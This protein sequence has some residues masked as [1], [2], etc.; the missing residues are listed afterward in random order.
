M[1]DVSP[2]PQV[3]GVPLVLAKY[4]HFI[5]RSLLLSRHP[6]LDA[7]DARLALMWQSLAARGYGSKS[8]MMHWVA[9]CFY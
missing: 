9:L 2:L 8:E 1:F 4:A 6:V 7:A 5:G 3:A